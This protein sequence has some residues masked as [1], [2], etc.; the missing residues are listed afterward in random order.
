MF[1]PAQNVYVKGIR[2]PPPKEED[3][4]EVPCMDI[5]FGAVLV[6]KTQDVTSNVA[7]SVD[8]VHADGLRGRALRACLGNGHDGATRL[9]I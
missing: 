2:A 5:T 7:V 8:V 9:K 6:N 4:G 1:P 3:M